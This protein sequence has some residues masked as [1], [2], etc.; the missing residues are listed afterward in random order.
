MLIANGSASCVTEASPE[1][2]RANIARRVGS[3]SAENVVLS[4]SEVILYLT[5]R[6]NTPERN[7][8]QV[9]ETH[10]LD[11]GINESSGPRRAA[12]RRNTKN[13]S[14]EE[15]TSELQSLRHL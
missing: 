4:R 12:R 9:L 2:S 8:C 7:P 13:R 14:E 5:Y 11:L 10:F 15:H 1:I 6:L 3:A